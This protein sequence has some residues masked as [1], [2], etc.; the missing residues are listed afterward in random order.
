MGEKKYNG[1]LAIVKESGPTSHDVVARLRRI[2]GMRRIGHCGTLDPLATGLLIACL[3][4]Y[5]RLADWLS[6]GA[7]EYCTTLILGATSNTYDAQGEI[8]PLKGAK[9]PTFEEL[10][11]A[12]VQFRG[13]IEQVPPAF[14]AV[15]VNGVRSY[16]LARRNEAVELKARTV[17][18]GVLEVL[19]FNY[20][21]VSLRIE[22]SRGTYIRSLAEDLGKSLGSGA[23][24]ETLSRQRIGAM[25]LINAFTLEQIESAI[26]ANELENCFTP[27]QTALSNIPEI[28]LE[29]EGLLAFSHGNPVRR[30]IVQN[31]DLSNIYAVYDLESNLYGMGE[32]E[33]GL[34]K[35]LKVL[36]NFSEPS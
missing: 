9:P 30:D 20:P 14:S 31:P 1:V 5:T 36:R 32:W 16:K 7:K 4:R 24:V 35:P 2:V 10:E 12:L 25:D 13:E 33:G 23:Y 21:R 19:N 26:A 28:I 11:S 8:V 18:I 27:P 17:R 15:K 34:L 6:L 22:C 29:K 3:G